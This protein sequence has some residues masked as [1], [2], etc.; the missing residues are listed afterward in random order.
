MKT[1]VSLVP[2]WFVFPNVLQQ[3]FGGN[4][5]VEVGLQLTLQPQSVAPPYLTYVPP[6]EVAVLRGGSYD[7][8]D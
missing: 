2:S 6:R 7:P 8:G 1:L 3:D 4:G 5:G